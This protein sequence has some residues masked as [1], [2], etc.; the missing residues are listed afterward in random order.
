KQPRVALSHL[1]AN[2]RH[3]TR[4]SSFAFLPIAEDIRE[5]QG[6]NRNVSEKA[7]GFEVKETFRESV[8]V[9]RHNPGLRFL[10]GCDGL[11]LDKRSRA[12]SVNCT[13]GSENNS[14]V[15]GIDCTAKKV[16]RI[17]IVPI[18]H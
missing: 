5:A 3:H 9:Q 2:P 16:K 7:S 17:T 12:V 18:Q 8:Q 15:M 10:P 13:T 11:F 14:L 6:N 4:R 1:P